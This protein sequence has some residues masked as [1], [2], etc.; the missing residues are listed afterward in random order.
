MDKNEIVDKTMLCQIIRWWNIKIHLKTG[1]FKS[2]QFLFLQMHQ[3]CGQ[4]HGK[5]GDKPHD[6]IPKLRTLF[7]QRKVKQITYHMWLWLFKPFN[8]N[9]FSVTSRRNNDGWTFV[10]R[11]KLNIAASSLLCTTTH[12]DL[13]R[14]E[15]SKQ[16]KR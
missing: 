7:Y 5:I 13:K 3:W 14:N 1:N 10:L 15:S 6:G 4:S 8:W 2:K 11:M 16:F 12:F 9:L